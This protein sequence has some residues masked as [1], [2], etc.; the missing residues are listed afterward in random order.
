M[1]SMKHTVTWNELEYGICIGQLLSGVLREYDTYD[2]WH[3]KG[4][5]ATSN[6]GGNAESVRTLE[7]LAV[8]V[9]QFIDKQNKMGSI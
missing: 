3:G 5:R 6:D 4:L 1:R 7:P 9:F 2:G 8:R